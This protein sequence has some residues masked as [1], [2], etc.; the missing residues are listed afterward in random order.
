MDESCVQVKASERAM[1]SASY[2]ALDA[3]PKEII[4]ILG[5]GGD[6][7]FVGVVLQTLQAGA[8]KEVC[9]KVKSRG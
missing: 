3:T 9:S 7:D 5:A 6:L 1:R 2:F 4:E 8:A